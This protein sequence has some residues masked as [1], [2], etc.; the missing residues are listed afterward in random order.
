[1]TRN[2]EEEMIVENRERKAYDTLT[3]VI[4]SLQT[5]D[6]FREALKQELDLLYQSWYHLKQSSERTKELVSK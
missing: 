3:G 4:Y 6:H 5:S 2:G 1:V